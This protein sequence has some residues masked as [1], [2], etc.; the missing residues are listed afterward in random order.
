MLEENVV[1][2]RGARSGSQGHAG[3][4]LVGGTA[5]EEKVGKTLWRCRERWGKGVRETCNVHVDIGSQWRRRLMVELC[6]DRGK[7]CGTVLSRFRWVHKN[8]RRIL[9]L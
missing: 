7:R 3:G 9:R 2:T 6:L 5:P 4:G 1:E 8:K